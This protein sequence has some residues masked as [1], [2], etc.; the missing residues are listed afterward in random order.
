MAKKKKKKPYD[1]NRSNQVKRRKVLEHTQ[2][3]VREMLNAM[4]SV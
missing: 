3:F 4:K 2:A 1:S